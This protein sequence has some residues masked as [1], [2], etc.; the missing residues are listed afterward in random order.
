MNANEECPKY[1]ALLVDTSI[2]DRHGLRLERGLLGKLT[3]FKDSKYI[4]VL[5]D[6]IKS[7]ISSH[8]ERHIKTARLS[9]EKSLSD[10]SEHLFFDGSALTD[11]KDKLISEEIIE[12]LAKKRLAD[13]IEKTG[14]L[15]LNS[16]DHVSL[17]KILDKY[18][19]NCPPFAEAGKKKNEFPDA[20]TL[21][22]VE[23]W[24]SSNDYQVLAVADDKDWESFCEASEFITY[25]KDLAAAL[26][27]LNKSSPKMV[28]NLLTNLKQALEGDEAQE[29]IETVESL[30]ESELDGYTPD[31]E[32]NSYHYWEADGCS[33]KLLSFEFHSYD[34]RIVMRKPEYVVLE[35]DAIISIEDIGDFSLSMQDPYDGDYVSLG[36]TTE[37][38]EV[39]FESEIL[40]TISGDLNGDVNN[41]DIHE[42][43]IVTKPSNINFGTIELDNYQED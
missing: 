42:I 1:D 36:S 38:I 17:S 26:A 34:F 33:V 27:Q 32:A 20:I 4:Y 39:E 13:F 5:P 23:G 9:L 15:V 11:A 14:A 37:S 31:Q 30:L 35:A 28:F 29:F 43:E 16:E 6:V 10:A 19:S 40:I 7:E 41:L 3:Q 22:A 12:S 18:F 21:F 25:E 2:F 8:L 24:A